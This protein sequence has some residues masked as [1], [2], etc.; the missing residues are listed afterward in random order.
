MQARAK[1]L[2]TCDGKTISVATDILEKNNPKWRR[3]GVVAST[4]SL[5]T[6]TLNWRIIQV[7]S[8]VPLDFWLNEWGLSPTELVKLVHKGDWERPFIQGW[9]KATTLQRH[10]AWAWAI[11][12]HVPL[13]HFTA[14]RKDLIA[15]LP[16]PEQEMYA[17]G[18]LKDPLQHQVLQSGHPIIAT[19]NAC[20]HTWSDGLALETAARLAARMSNDKRHFMPGQ[21]FHKALLRY[22]HYCPTHLAGEIA[23]ILA[24]KST[25]GNGWQ[26]LAT[27]FIDTVQFR[28]DMINTINPE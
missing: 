8:R 24:P 20:T 9:A 19:L 3:D 25:T 21:T 1:Q 16:E 6:G 10:P 27:L 26:K 18:V 17:M 13:K 14:Y 7:V 12:K 15:S 23:G 4:K 22:S 11:L 5:K 2:F 28:H